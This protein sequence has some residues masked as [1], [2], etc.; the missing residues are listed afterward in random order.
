MKIL[1]KLRHHT[2]LLYN[3]F[4]KNAYIIRFY[5]KKMKVIEPNIATEKRKLVAKGLRP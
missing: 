5:Q 4:P 1:I 3:S 2:K